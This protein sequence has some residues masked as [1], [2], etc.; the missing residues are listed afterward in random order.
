M[1][2]TEL[3]R[4]TP[5]KRGRSLGSSRSSGTKRKPRSPEEFARIYGSKARVE[6]VKRLPCAACGYDRDRCENHHIRGD[7]VSRKA[8]YTTI[9]PLCAICH[10][11]WHDKGRSYVAQR[12]GLDPE[13]A[14]RTTE[15]AWQAESARR[16]GS[17]A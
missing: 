9:I 17:A 13:H 1:K 7:G 4:K 11:L 8:D 6:F 2:R 12:F 16:A 10:D 3:R 14:A 15:H 5:M